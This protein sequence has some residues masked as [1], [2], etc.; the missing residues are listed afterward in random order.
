MRLRGLAALIALLAVVAGLPAVL[1]RLGGFPVPAHAPGWQQAGR[2]LLHR[3]NGRLFLAAV[4]DVSWLAWAAFTAAVIAEVQA[5]VRH[6]AAPRLRLGGLQ[7]SAAQLVALTVLAFGPGSVSPGP[8]APVPA[9]TAPVPA[10]TAPVPAR[11]A[12]VPAR[13]RAPALARS[14]VAARSSVQALARTDVPTPTP[15]SPRMMSMGFYQLVT[16]RPGDCL[17]T[18]AQHYLGN[19]DLYP[20]IVKLNLGHEMG[21]GQVFTD[22]SLIWPGWVLQLPDSGPA[23]H[24][25]PGGSEHHAAHPSH[26]HRFRR[27]HPA[28]GGG[29][30]GTQG[31][32][33]GGHHPGR[34][35]AGGHS[36]HGAGGNGAG[37]HGTGQDGTGRHSAGRHRAEGQ[38]GG[39][40]S[41]ARPGP[42]VPAAAIF[43]AGLLAGGAAVSLARLRHRQRQ[44]RQLGRRIPL[45]T[46]APV[47]TAEH[48]LRA[49]AAPGQ[50]G[51]APT[52]LRAVLGELGAGLLAADRDIP[53]ITGLRLRPAGLEVLLAG[54]PGEPPPAP[55]TVP[56]SPDGL[57]WWLPRPDAEQAGPY[58]PGETG[59]L[60]PGLV[61]IGGTDGGYLLA[62]LE[63][64]GVTT[65]Q[66]PSALAGQVLATA[67]AELATSEL[68]G[69]YDLVLVGYDELASAGSRV[70]CCRDLDQALDLLAAKAVASRRG[71]AGQDP[72]SIRGLRLADP[73]NPDWVLSLLVSRDAPAAGQ[74]ALLLDLAGE[75]A[76]IA[77]LVP[78]GPAAP[79]DRAVPASIQ[80]A[81]DPASP[82]GIVADLVP[83]GIRAWPQ[84]LEAA[85]Y[86]A[87][88]SMFTVAAEEADVAP[89]APPYDGCRWPPP[90]PAD[91]GEAPGGD[92]GPGDDPMPGDGEPA[93]GPVPSGPVP[94]GGWQALRVGMLGSLTING[95][96][97]L[98]P[99]QPASLLL[100]LA[101]GGPDGLSGPELRY[102]LGADPGHPRPLAW[103]HELVTRTRRQLGPAPGGRDWIE[104]SGTGHHGGRYVLHP[105]VR[106]DWAEFDALASAGLRDRDPARLR[107]AI[108]L[109]RGQP[110]AGCGLWSLDPALLET[111]RAQIVDAAQLLS[112]LELAAGDCS[113]AA[114]AART[115]LAGDPAAEQLWRALMRAEH[116][117][118]NPAGLHEAWSRCLDQVAG[119]DADGEPDPR[120]ALLYRQLADRCQRGA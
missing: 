32:P 42:E 4:R 103:L 85:D 102:L 115:G 97:A 13:A 8:A 86:Q 72:A 120:T 95:S 24:S 6:R 39:G 44:A 9:R 111:V 68:A 52:A 36:E 35:G 15:T 34:H 26:E 33:G 107:A 79:P 58:S 82:G 98:L 113:A 62:D 67:A 50:P 70:T 118:G 92:P 69:W 60:L 25:R 112:G 11:T 78:G 66:G 99:P 55:F 54:P 63:Y 91:T 64:L 104:H 28:A 73:G 41:P 57:S 81:A 87:L 27:P 49:A 22:P 109:I 94:S 100:L 7:A 45:P 53:G 84:P 76:G 23:G 1:Y 37:Q 93:S 75:P 96:P 77:A 38:P 2:V 14:A 119:A 88:A 30:P 51:W 31:Q 40:Q 116:A 61:T 114:H 83:L 48:R 18:I 110:L 5:A 56:A 20:E 17:W 3:D 12:A 19:G 106:F 101:L 80:L 16:V 89:G 47:L 29:S 108:G 105:A 90:V 65:V 74:L 59:D 21:G 46:G 43:A 71:L 10:K 117:A